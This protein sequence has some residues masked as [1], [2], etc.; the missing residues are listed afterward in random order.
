MALSVSFSHYVIKSHNKGKTSAD[1][2][3]AR[4]LSVSNISSLAT[5]Y[6]GALSY[7]KQSLAQVSLALLRYGGIQL[8]SPCGLHLANVSGAKAVSQHGIHLPGLGLGPFAMISGRTWKHGPS[9]FA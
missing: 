6:W 7:L 4:K 8:L 9:L 1:P 2:K 3:T 5:H